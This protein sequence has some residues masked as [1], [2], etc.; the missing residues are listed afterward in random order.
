MPRKFFTRSNLKAIRVDQGDDGEPKYLERKVPAGSF[1]KTD[2]VFAAK[3]RTQATVPS[4]LFKKKEAEWITQEI[5]YLKCIDKDEK[6]ILIPLSH[7]GKFNAI[8]EKG[9]LNQHSVYTMK[10][11]LSDLKLPVRV[12]LLFGKAPVVPCIFTGMLFVKEV[13]ENDVIIA[14]TILNRR[15]VLMDLPTNC[16]C[17]V[18]QASR[19]EDFANLKTFEDAQKLC[20]KYAHMYST[21]IKLSPEMDTGQS[22]KVHVPIDPDLT[23]KTDDALRALDLITDISLTDDEP[24]DFFMESD[25]DSLRSDDQPVMLSGTIV[26]LSQF[27]GSQSVTNA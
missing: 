19:E 1:L 17:R 15:N 5:K 8:Y 7:R 18:Q 14:S 25:T 9:K 11:I 21:L 24:R 3:W 2:S 26:E 6:E 27:T 13:Q 4:G 23:R 12:R 22:T 10:D 20:Q 16:P